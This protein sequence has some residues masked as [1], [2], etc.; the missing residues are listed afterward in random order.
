MTWRTAFREVVKLKHFIS[1]QPTVETSHRLATWATVAEGDFA[2]WSI[3]GAQDAIQ[4]YNE[5]GGD[6]AKLQLSFEWNWLRE[7]FNLSRP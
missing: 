5:V 2:E 6:L 3:R 4:Y 1:T 7:R